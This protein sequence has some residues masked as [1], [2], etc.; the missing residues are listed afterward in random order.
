[1][2]SFTR[3]L[4]TSAKLLPFSFFLS[5]VARRIEAVGVNELKKRFERLRLTPPNTPVTPQLVFLKNL[6]V[7]QRNRTPMGRS[8]PLFNKYDLREV[9]EQH[10]Q[11]ARDAIAASSRSQIEGSTGEALV[12]ELEKEHRVAPLLL[13]EDQ[14]G[15]E[16]E[17]TRVDVSD[18]PRRAVFDR[19]RP[20]LIPGQR[21]RYVVPFQGDPM[22]WHCRPGTFTL[23]PPRGSIESS[24]LVFEF[25]V[26]NDEVSRTRQYFDSELANVKQYIQ[27][28]V[29]DIEAHNQSLGKTLLD[30]LS[31]RREQLDHAAKQIEGLGLPVRK[32]V[33]PTLTQAPNQRHSSR[34][35]Q[36][37]TAPSKEYDVALS[38]AGEDREYVE[39][40]AEIL[41]AVGSKFS[42]T[43]S[44]PYSCGVAISQI[45]WTR[46]T[47]SDRDSS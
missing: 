30:A 27:Y 14:M 33:A 32:R 31:R 28:A 36:K 29:P 39:E 43:N 40:A 3:S 42:T 17:E 7:F 38:F 13:L 6:S 44:R 11:K 21:L 9:L 8:E 25:E 4:I 10:K 23:N 5:V 1:V 15:V 18:D 2:Q 22:L 46:C 26:P 45:I 12:A 41:Q 19:S 37:A 34:P 20:C 47:A 16:S 24:D 35:A